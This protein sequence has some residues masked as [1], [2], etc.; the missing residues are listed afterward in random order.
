MIAAIHP[1]GIFDPGRSQEGEF[2]KDYIG[3]LLDEWDIK[4]YLGS[5]SSHKRY[6]LLYHFFDK[7]RT[8]EEYQ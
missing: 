4:F 2:F 8:G 5:K 3:N 1:L 6:W 7:A